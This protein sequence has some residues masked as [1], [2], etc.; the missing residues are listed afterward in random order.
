MRP[1]NSRLCSYSHDSVI[2]SYFWHT[3]L[4]SYGYFIEY[5]YLLILDMLPGT[6]VTHHLKA[7]PEIK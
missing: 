4:L 1:Q 5:N 6:R 2:F 7:Y 3:Y